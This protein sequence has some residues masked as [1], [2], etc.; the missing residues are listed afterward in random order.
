MSQELSPGHSPLRGAA[1]G[2][3]GK[4]FFVLAS[5]VALGG[6]GVVG[7]DEKQVTCVT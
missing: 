1:I 5:L 7:R 2:R 3:V 4:R 6:F